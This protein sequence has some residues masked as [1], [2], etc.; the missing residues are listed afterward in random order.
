MGFV[1]WLVHAELII[2]DAVCLWCTVAHILAFGLFAVIVTTTQTV[3]ADS[4]HL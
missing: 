2:I 4:Q 3:L 1:L